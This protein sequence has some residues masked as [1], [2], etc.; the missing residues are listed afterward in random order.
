[1]KRIRQHIIK[2]LQK[3]KPGLPKAVYVDLFLPQ[4]PFKN[5]KIAHVSDIHIG[6]FAD[7]RYCY[8]IA[9]TVN[10]LKP[11]LVAFT[12]D[13]ISEKI[14]NVREEFKFLKKIKAPFGKYGVLGNRELDYNTLKECNRAY[15][16]VGIELLN[17]EIT[18]IEKEGKKFN[19]LGIL[20][21][22]EKG[23]EELEKE[24]VPTLMLAHQ[25]RAAYHIQEYDL[26]P[27]LMLCGHT[28]CGQIVPFGRK[29]LETQEQPFI[30]GI[31]VFGRTIVYVSCG[32][33]HTLIPFR[34]LTKSEIALVTIN[35]VR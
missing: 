21:R 29:I 34:F 20:E 8:H 3:R 2:I 6:E 22:S 16:N 23:L 13:I 10:A 9:K 19:I 4:F 27:L 1:M 11:D 35:P 12:G 25:P 5:F 18:T 30:K 33:G 26:D 28:H 7:R 14:E 15:K 32:A 31:N 17:N 24:A